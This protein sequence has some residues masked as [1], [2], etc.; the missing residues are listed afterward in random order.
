MDNYSLGSRS[1]P[2][3]GRVEGLDLVPVEVVPL[4]PAST[5]IRFTVRRRRIALPLALFVLTCASTFLTGIWGKELDEAAGAVLRSDPSAA[6][7]HLLIAVREGVVY[8]GSLMTILI[9]HE[10]GHF[11]QARRYRV[12]ASFPYFIPMP[13]SPIGTMGAVIAMEAHTGGRKALFD[14]G[15]TGPL[16]GLV[17]TLIFSIVGL[18]LSRPVLTVPDA[19]SGP[20]VA[21]P[22]V[23]RIMIQTFFPHLTEGYGIDLHPMAYAGWVGLLITSLNLFPIGQLD[24]GHVLYGLLRTKAH[25]VA[26]LVLFGATAAVFLGTALL[27]DPRL[28]G[29]TLMLLLLYLM[30]PRH[31]PTADDNVPLGFWRHVL[32][33]LTLAFL[34][35]GFTPIPFLM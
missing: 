4:P 12:Y 11:F 18:N 23:F 3:E 30:G 5:Q 20:V 26:T 35:L 19:I 29:W 17:P 31:P 6:L 7:A 25:A 9:C 21:M 32:G 24:G 15:I 2:P 27:H 10:A 1:D 13:L 28:M 16:A 8:A 22:P 34:P 33:W 14:I